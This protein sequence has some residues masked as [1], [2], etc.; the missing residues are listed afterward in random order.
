MSTNGGAVGEWNKTGVYRALNG[1]KE[2]SMR[3]N[4]R[5]V[6]NAWQIMPKT[7]ATNYDTTNDRHAATHIPQQW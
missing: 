1:W 2:E 7:I 3:I 4:E 6:Q 5:D